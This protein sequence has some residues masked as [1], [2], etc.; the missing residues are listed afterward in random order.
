MLVGPPE[1][2]CWRRAVLST[3]VNYIHRRTLSVLAPYI[4]LGYYWTNS[5]F[6]LLTIA[7][8]LAYAIGQSLKGLIRDLI[9]T[10]QGVTLAV[11]FYSR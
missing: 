4:E 5:D 3:V 10:R 1:L 11:A 6:A 9:G 7:F 2:A 8:R